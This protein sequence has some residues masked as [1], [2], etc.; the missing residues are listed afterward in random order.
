[1]I[2]LFV[3][4]RSG[5]MCRVIRVRFKPY[6]PD[7]GYDLSWIDGKLM[8]LGYY[9]TVIFLPEDTKFFNEKECELIELE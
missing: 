7:N 4:T 1:M 2:T 3:A 6:L 8:E 9:N 5:L